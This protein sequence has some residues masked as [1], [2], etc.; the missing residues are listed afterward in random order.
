M[1]GS[2]APIEPELGQVL[3]VTNKEPSRYARVS[4]IQDGGTVTLND[5]LLDTHYT[6][7]AQKY[8]VLTHPDVSTYTAYV[9]EHKNGRDDWV[10]TQRFLLRQRAEREKNHYTLIQDGNEAVRIREETRS[11]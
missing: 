7:P 10:E 4:E 3:T 11:L 9:I 5:L 1:V 2:G 8:D 6:V